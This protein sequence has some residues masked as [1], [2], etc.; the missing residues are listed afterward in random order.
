MKNL[1]QALMFLSEADYNYFMASTVLSPEDRNYLST[2]RTNFKKLC[3]EYD[4]YLE[5]AIG[6]HVNGRTLVYTDSHQLY[7]TALED[8]EQEERLKKFLKK[9]TSKS[10]KYIALQKKHEHVIYNVQYACSKLEQ[11]RQ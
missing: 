8:K 2:E 10:F 1:M 3:K 7:L 5:K 9:K 6:Y 4:Q 11:R